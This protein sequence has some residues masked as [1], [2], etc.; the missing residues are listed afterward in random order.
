MLRTGNTRAMVLIGPAQEAFYGKFLEFGTKYMAAQPFMAAAFESAVPAMT[1]R[2]SEQLKL[3]IERAAA[4][5]K[6]A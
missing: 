4:G 1:A 3:K 5:N 2:F 6:V